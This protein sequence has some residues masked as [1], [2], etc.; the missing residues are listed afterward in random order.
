MCDICDKK[1]VTKRHICDKMSQKVIFVTQKKCDEKH[2]T[3]DFPSY[4]LFLHG[5]KHF[6]WSY[7][8]LDSSKIEIDSFIQ[9]IFKRHMLR[10][11]CDMCDANFLLTLFSKLLQILLYTSHYFEALVM[12]NQLLK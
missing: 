7:S 11:I 2:G 12:Y 6:I 9:L 10:H 4:L 5:N 8:P 1:C 3:H